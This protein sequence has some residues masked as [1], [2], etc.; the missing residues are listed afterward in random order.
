MIWFT[1]SRFL[2]LPW[3]PATFL[4]VDD[5]YLPPFLYRLE[6]SWWLDDS[7]IVRGTKVLIDSRKLE[8]YFA[9]GAVD[10]STAYSRDDQDPVVDLS[11]FTTV[12]LTSFD[13]REIV[14]EVADPENTEYTFGSD[15]DIAGRRRVHRVR[16]HL[17]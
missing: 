8:K 3:A 6:E 13:H 5:N 9:G 12:R 15:F 16:R 11:T 2:A 14:T 1:P 17:P 10:T 4:F 7:E